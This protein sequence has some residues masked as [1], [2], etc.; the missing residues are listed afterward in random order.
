MPLTRR[1]MGDVEYCCLRTAKE[2]CV[3]ATITD[4]RNWAEKRI[5]ISR[6]DTVIAKAARR[7]VK[8][9]QLV[10]SQISNPNGRKGNVMAFTI[11]PEGIAAVE[12]FDRFVKEWY[13]L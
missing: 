9:G 13:E 5:K 3:A 1:N 10:E 12:V 4:I 2:K 8:E 6:Q 11:T 7:R